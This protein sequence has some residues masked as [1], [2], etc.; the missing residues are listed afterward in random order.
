M[1]IKGALVL[2]FSLALLIAGCGGGG[3][4]FQLP[5]GAGSGGVPS[6]PA[7]DPSTATATISGSI[8]FEGDA[9][10]M[11]RIQMAAD[12]YCQQTAAGATSQEVLVTDDGKLQNVMI[13]L[14]SVI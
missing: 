12:P 6:G 10:E 3:D 9:P 14:R 8:M 11:P 7:Y 4:D 13:F 5:A 1:N 2:I